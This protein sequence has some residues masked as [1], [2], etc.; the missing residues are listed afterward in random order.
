MIS[1]CRRQIIGFFVYVWFWVGICFVG[2]DISKAFDTNSCP[3][4]FRVISGITGPDKVC[5]I[6]HLLYNTSI[7]VR[8]SS[9]LA[10]PFYTTIGTPQGDI[11]WTLFSFYAIFSPPCESAAHVYPQG[12]FLTWPCLM[13]QVRRMMYLST[14]P[15]NKSYMQVYPS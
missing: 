4:L 3:T 5:C 9:S 8:I 13:K 11:G 10:L 2:L 12:Q 7:S 15:A 14:S 1:W 6:H